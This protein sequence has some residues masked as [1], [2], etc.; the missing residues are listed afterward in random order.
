MLGP[1]RHADTAHGL[2][3]VDHGGKKFLAGDFAPH[4]ERE[5]RRNRHAAGVDHRGAM[6]IVHFQDMGECAHDEGVASAVCLASP[7]PG[8]QLAPGFGVAT[9]ER[10][11]HRVESKQRRLPEIARGHRLVADQPDQPLG[12]ALAVHP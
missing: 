5:G 9:G 2:E 12:Q 1:H 8:E 6:Q 10:A 4:A 7:A 11:C 3:S